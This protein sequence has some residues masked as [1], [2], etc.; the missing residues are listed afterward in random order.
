MIPADPRQD[1][2]TLRGAGSEMQTVG[3]PFVIPEHCLTLPGATYSDP[4]GRR[5]KHDKHK[6]TALI[7][8]SDGHG[9]AH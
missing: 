9:P 4:V 5:Q 6:G 2:G 8:F 7:S 3:K 1:V